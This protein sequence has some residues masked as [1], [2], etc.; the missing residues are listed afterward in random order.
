MALMGCATAQFAHTA[1]SAH[2]G[3]MG[4]CIVLSSEPHVA[5]GYRHAFLAEAMADKDIDI[6][7]PLS[8]GTVSAAYRH[9]GNLD[10]HEQQLAAAYAIHVGRGVQVGVA[11]RWLH[12]GTSDPHYE[13][14][15]YLGA[16]AMAR[17]EPHSSL[18][19]MLLAGSRPWDER[20]PWH[21]HAQLAYRPMPVWTTMLE[22][23]SEE[24]LRMRA[25]M[26]YLYHNSLALRVGFSTAPL[27]LTFGLGICVGRMQ[28][29]LAVET[30]RWL[31]ITPQTSLVLWL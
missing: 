31:G 4:G 9:H 7:L 22:V 26:Q 28:L 11:A 10:Y 30:H 24:R 23:E 29:D 15:S 13:Q 8:S 19:I 3:A 25:G 1:H 16:D 21:A 17:F 5:M 18:G 20:R 12:L 27:A 14:L 6:L 2:S